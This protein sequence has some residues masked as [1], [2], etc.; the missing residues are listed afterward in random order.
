MIP[1]ASEY[2][3]VNGVSGALCEQA[4]RRERRVELGVENF[5][6]SVDFSRRLPFL[7][8]SFVKFG[9]AVSSCL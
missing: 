1:A 6:P 4:D 8:R 9:F 5:R 3:A 7:V 2:L